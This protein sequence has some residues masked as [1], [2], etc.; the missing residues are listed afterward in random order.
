MATAEIIGS[1]KAFSADPGRQGKIDRVV[2][3]R[4]EDGI[5]RFVTIPD[6]TYTM[7][8]AQEAI[9]KFET[10]RRLAAPAKFTV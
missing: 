8:A 3:Y 4:M 2:I 6:E 7:A 10:E 1:E 9:R 5:S